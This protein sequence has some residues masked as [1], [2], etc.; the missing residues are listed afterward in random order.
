VFET[1]NENS[2]IVYLNASNLV[3]YDVIQ[4][5][6]VIIIDYKS[7]NLEILDFIIDKE[8][9][10]IFYLCSNGYIYFFNTEDAI[11]N[12]KYSSADNK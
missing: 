9:E 12:L 4:D 11:N 6:A 2:L 8:L 3:L 10:I 5:K 1:I 7:Q